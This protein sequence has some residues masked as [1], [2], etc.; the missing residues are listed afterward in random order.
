MGY[1]LIGGL[2]FL[3]LINPAIAF[4]ENYGIIEA[5]ILI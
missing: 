5:G 4:P 1:S 3:R 2:L